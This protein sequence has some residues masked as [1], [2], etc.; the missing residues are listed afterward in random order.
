MNANEF[1]FGNETINAREHTNAREAIQARKNPA[2]ICAIMIGVDG[3]RR[4][5][6]LTLARGDAERLEAAGIGF[7]YLSYNQA[8][9]RIMSVPVNE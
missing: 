2:T 7:A 1:T 3:G 6:Y 8:S 9:G 5:A 4:V